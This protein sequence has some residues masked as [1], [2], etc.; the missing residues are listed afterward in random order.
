MKM[1]N[2]ISMST[3]G[4]HSLFYAHRDTSICP[5]LFPL[6]LASHKLTKL[7]YVLGTHDSSGL[8]T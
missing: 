6:Y 1:K 5:I 3:R 2:S 4:R 8:L 7:A